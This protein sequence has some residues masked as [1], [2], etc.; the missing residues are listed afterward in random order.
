MKIQNTTPLVLQIHDKLDDSISQWQSGVKNV[1]LAPYGSSG[2]TIEIP[3]T[4]AAE[5]PCVR[6]WSEYEAVQILAGTVPALVNQAVPGV[7]LGNGVAFDGVVKCSRNEVGAFVYRIMFGER[8]SA[9]P[10]VD[11]SVCGTAVTTVGDVVKTADAASNLVGT[12][13]S[14]IAAA[15]SGIGMSGNIMVTFTGGAQ[16]NQA[17][18]TI[19]ARLK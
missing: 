7:G 11:R 15:P 17:G 12:V 1:S 9:D 16:H 13:T 10:I 5:S 6:L 3:D 18:Y 8:L 4:I 2:D 14:A 19:Y